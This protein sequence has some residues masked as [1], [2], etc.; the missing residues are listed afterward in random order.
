LKLD[1]LGKEIR[2]ELSRYGPQAGMAELVE[3][4]PAIVGEA[5][6]RNAWPARIA[7]DGTVHINTADS[8]WSFE[9]GH[10]SAEIAERLGVPGVRFAPGP[11]PE[12]SEEPS[13]TVYAVSPQDEEMARAIASS[14]SDE[15]LRESVQKAVSLSLARERGDPSI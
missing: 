9:L 4:W 6:A 10:R 13:K 14:I 11:L 12:A 1:P 15:K 5:I 2:K 8:I 3:A 7:R